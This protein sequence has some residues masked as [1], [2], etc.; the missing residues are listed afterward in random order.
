MVC[1]YC[2]GQTN[3]TNSRHN[4]K[5][6]TVWRRRACQNCHAIFSTY[7][8]ADYEKSWVVSDDHNNLS[9]FVRDKLLVSLF[10]SCQHRPTALTDAIGLTDTVIALIA[11]NIV[12]G[13]ISKRLV[14]AMSLQTLGN[15]DTAAATHYKA[16]H[17][18]TID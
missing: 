5:R 14:A 9:P 8:A 4:K 2:G 7:E 18:K 13:A 17:P 11:P 6:N 1:I 12:D 3:V 10:K 15:F 16:F